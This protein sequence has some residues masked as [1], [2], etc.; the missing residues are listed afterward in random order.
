LDRSE[1]LCYEVQSYPTSY[2]QAQCGCF[3]LLWIPD[4]LGDA[5]CEI[6]AVAGCAKVR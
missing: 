1:M 2:A 4:C 6:L 5:R 3:P